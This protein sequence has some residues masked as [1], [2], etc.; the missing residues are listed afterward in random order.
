ME[1]KAEELPSNFNQGAEEEDGVELEVEPKSAT[2]IRN[3][4]M[5]KLMQ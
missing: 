1:F 3:R 4:F 5:S 2:D